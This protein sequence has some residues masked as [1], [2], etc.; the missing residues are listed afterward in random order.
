MAKTIPV[1]VVCCSDCF[2]NQGLRLEAIRLGSQHGRCPRCGSET[3]SGLS[4]DQC[5]ELLERFFIEGSRSIGSFGIS[6][7]MSGAGNPHRIEFDST[8]QSDFETI[9][10]IDSLGLRLRSPK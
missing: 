7:Y 5:G 2:N 9:M 10:G 3:G 4:E 8:L 1:P 6:P